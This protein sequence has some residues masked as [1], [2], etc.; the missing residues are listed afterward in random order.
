MPALV[1]EQLLDE[2]IARYNHALNASNEI[3]R[4]K[5]VLLNDMMVLFYCLSFIL[6]IFFCII[7]VS[8]KL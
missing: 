4:N 5:N 8:W 2:E 7:H 6:F 3:G 1:P